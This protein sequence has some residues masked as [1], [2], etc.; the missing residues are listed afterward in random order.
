MKVIKRLGKLFKKNKFQNKLLFVSNPRVVFDVGSHKGN[1]A[2][3]T[4]EEYPFANIFCFEPNSENYFYIKDRFKNDNKIFIYNLALFN[5]D[6][7][8]DF[9]YNEN[10]ETNSLFQSRRIH[11]EIDDFTKTNYLMKVKTLTLDSFCL[12]NN[13]DFINFL[14]I[15]AQGA[16]YEIIEGAI[17]LLKLG[18]IEAIQVEVEFLMIYENQKLFSTVNEL[19]NELNYYI[20][21]IFNINYLS[22]GKLAW[23]DLIYKK[24]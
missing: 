18:R 13:V 20:V 14:K 15:D 4:R 2:K 12:E 8:L 22:D 5:S 23:C 17:N 21:K 11:D 9:H 24:F 6:G 10:D 19:L 1:F 16:S 3:S 7:V